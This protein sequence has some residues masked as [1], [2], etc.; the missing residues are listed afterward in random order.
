MDPI[1]HAAFAL[2]LTAL[3]GLWVAAWL[4]WI[5]GG[6]IRHWVVRY[7]FPSK[8]LGGERRDAIKFLSHDE[9]DMY[10]ATNLSMPAFLRGV[11][12]CPGCM[13]AH[14]SY[15]GLLAFYAACFLVS[16]YDLILASLPAFPL[17][18]A[19]S[20]FTGRA[21]FSKF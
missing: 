5:F 13:S 11:M 17:V 8:W 19:G 4:H 7:L 20:A 3:N 2:L 6:E 21:L 10:I 9:M 14:L 1:S 15:L 18:W 16:S 12:T